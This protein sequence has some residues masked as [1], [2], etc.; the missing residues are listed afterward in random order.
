MTVQQL[1]NAMNMELTLAKSSII[2]V[3]DASTSAHY[4]YGEKGKI[5]LGG[6]YCGHSTSDV[7]D[8]EILR[9]DLNNNVLEVYI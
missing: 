9:M 2:Q 1:L 6:D 4:R 8:S 5:L 3:M 7:L